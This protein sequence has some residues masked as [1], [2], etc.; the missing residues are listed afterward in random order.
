MT[1]LLATTQRG[2]GYLHGSIVRIS[3]NHEFRGRLMG[4]LDHLK[5][6]L[7]FGHAVDS[8]RGI[9]HVMSAMLRV[10]LGEHEEFDVI[11]KRWASTV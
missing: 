8:P 6:A 2:L 4:M 10:D 3:A 1:V 9:E 5:E 7:A 11:L